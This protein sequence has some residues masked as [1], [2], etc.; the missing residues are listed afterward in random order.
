MHKSL[1]TL[2][3]WGFTS[4]ARRCRAFTLAELVVAVGILA[5]MMALAGQVFSI[6]VR[7]TGQATALTSVSQALRQLEL[8]L[9]DDLRHA[10]PGNSLILI[11]SNPVNAYWTQRGAGADVDGKPANGYPHPADPDRE[12]AAGNP[13]A[14][15]AD[16]L[17]IFTARTALS[18]VYPAVSSDLQQ[19]VYGH[20]VLG[21]YEPTGDAP[22]APAFAF[23]PGP[24][25]FPTNPAFGT[26]DPNAVSP[27]PAE[28]WHLARRSM[29][30][31]QAP[32]PDNVAP[33]WARW[34][35]GVGPG[36]TIDPTDNPVL[37]GETDVV[38]GFAYDKRVLV[39]TG[40]YPWY[41][42]EILTNDAKPYARS[43]LDPDPPA[44]L[45]DR[46]GHYLL[47]HCASFKVEWTLDPRG[48]AF[49]G[50]LD[51][52]REVFWFDQGDDVDPLASL[53][54]ALEDLAPGTLR[55]INLRYVLEAVT[56]G[57]GPFYSLT[58]RFRTTAAGGDPDWILSPDGRPN[59]VVFTASRR[60]PATPG[61]PGDL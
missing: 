28:S 18:T 40:G 59:L 1:C 17:M 16:I 19:V 10:E 49:A 42:P 14:P 33:A 58:D 3:L 32:Q 57:R 46:L 50:R 4:R 29:L 56:L 12:D 13:V 20:A 60:A 15:R 37:L 53:Q 35:G 39:P 51:D 27:V 55:E 8:T 22:P 23:V 7:S 44:P 25:A 24:D 47:P 45:A 6:T 5:L 54:R 34:L 41:L 43:R 48:E 36:E 61:G 52:E 26:P 38:G 30:L 31:T 11:Q 2:S 21:E 9:R